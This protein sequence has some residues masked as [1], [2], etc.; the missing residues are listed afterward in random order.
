MYDYYYVNYICIIHYISRLIG[1]CMKKPTPPKARNPVASHA[2][3]SGS[4]VHADQ[5]LKNKPLRKSKHKGNNI[6]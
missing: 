6:K 4:G 1:V 2:Q 5:N 3:R